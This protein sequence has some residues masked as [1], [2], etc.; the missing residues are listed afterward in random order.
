MLRQK[1]FPAVS[2]LE[3]AQQRRKVH[4]RVKVVVVVVVVVVHF[5]IVEASNNFWKAC[6]TIIP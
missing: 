6:N 3:I 5:G 1:V 4:I 2:I